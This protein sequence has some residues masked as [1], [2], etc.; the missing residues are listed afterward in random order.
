MPALL[1]TLELSQG[2]LLWAL[3]YGRDPDQIL[4]DRVRYLRRMDIPPAAIR[5]EG[6][7]N[8]VTYDFFDLVELGLA[9]TAL[10]LGFRPREISAGLVGGREDM[11]RFYSDTWREIP[12]QALHQDWV[13]SRGR[14]KPM[15]GEEMFVR[16]HDRRSEKFG[17]IDF[18][19]FEEASAALPP[20]EP[21]E[22]F[23]DGPRRLIP[24][25]RLMIQWVV[26]AG[27]APATKPGP[28]ANSSS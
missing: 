14:I 15:M 5:A 25:K 24:L 26:W 23:E 2:Q 8:R 11:R 17:K 27:E 22:R 6:S 16:L 28:A 21:V 18:V 4:K 12:E 13:K 10:D 3:N 19:G 20:F 1:P 9:V 7:G